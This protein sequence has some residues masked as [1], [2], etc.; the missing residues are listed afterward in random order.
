[1]NILLNKINEEFNLKLMIFKRG[2]DFLKLK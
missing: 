1:M 2:I